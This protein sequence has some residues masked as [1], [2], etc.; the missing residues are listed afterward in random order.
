MDTTLGLD[1][2]ATFMTLLGA[3]IDPPTGSGRSAATEALPLEKRAIL[4]HEL[5]YRRARRLSIITWANTLLVAI[6]GGAVGL[7]VQP[8]NSLSTEQ[9]LLSTAAIVV[10]VGLSAMWWR[11]HRRI[12]RDLLARRSKLDEMLGVDL[13]SDHTDDPLHVRGV[14]SIVLLGIAAVLALWIP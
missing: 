10:L 11:S 6:T 4:Q 2:R 14:Y 1:V 7:Q 8:E 12:E 9:R 5:D 13:G 3:D